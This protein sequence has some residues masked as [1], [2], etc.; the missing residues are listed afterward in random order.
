[1]FVLAT[2]LIPIFGLLTQDVKDTDIL[3]SQTFAVDRA[4]LVL[5]TLLDEVPFDN[6]R[7]GNPAILDGPK[8][9]QWAAHLFP[10]AA[11][12]GSGYACEGIATDGRGISYHLYVR[13]DP[14]E[15]TTATYTDGE[16]FF[17]YYPNPTVEDQQPGWASMAER[18]TI[19]EVNE[20]RPSIY[21]PGGIDNPGRVLPPY[22]YLN[23][24]PNTTLW[25]PQH[26]FIT[27]RRIRVDQRM[28]TRP[29]ADGR[30]YLMQRILLQIR[31]NLAMS[32]YSR[33][34][35]P[36]GRPQRFHVV[37]FKGDLQ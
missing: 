21:T 30:Y 1:M 36:T 2:A 37:T 22:R 7:P 9:A 13:S 5:N 31:W 3:V 34:T 15:D 19:A 32:E 24:P 8:A 11:R 18:A 25:G 14:I 16:L 12:L 6:L 20:Q 26:E 28:V 10:G 33:P 27:G 4:R 35:S 17:T 23:G 29:R